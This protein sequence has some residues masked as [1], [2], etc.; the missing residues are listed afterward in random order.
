MELL[1]ADLKNNPV[2][3]ENRN[4]ES[5]LEAIADWTEDMEGYYQNTNQPI[6]NNINWKVF[7]DILIAASMYE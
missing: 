1:I 3:W 4:L 7:A 5:Y 2:Y 6:P